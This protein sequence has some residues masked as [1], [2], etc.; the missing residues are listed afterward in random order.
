MFLGSLSMS[1][2]FRAWCLMILMHVWVVCCA[3]LKILSY[4][5]QFDIDFNPALMKMAN[6]EKNRNRQFYEKLIHAKYGI[7]ISSW[8]TF[9]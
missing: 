4:N 3:E 7:L 2:V 9:F 6:I 8:L 5:L 1:M